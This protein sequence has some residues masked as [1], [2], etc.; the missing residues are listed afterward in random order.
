MPRSPPWK[1]EGGRLQ[2]DGR[3]FQVLLSPL[4]LGA[5][6]SAGPGVGGPESVPCITQGC[7][8]L[9]SR[10]S[11][12]GEESVRS[13]HCFS[14]PGGPA[15]QGMR[16]RASVTQGTSFPGFLISGHWPSGFHQQVCSDPPRAAGL[17]G[18]PGPRGLLFEVL[19][20]SLHLPLP[21]RGR[22]SL[23]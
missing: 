6:T 22:S 21:G 3:W 9:C 2:A 11:G 17:P 20:L 13:E 16:A 23:T 18:P 5:W 12:A 4:C 14:S 8:F 10:A 1:R 15:H 7:P 19:P